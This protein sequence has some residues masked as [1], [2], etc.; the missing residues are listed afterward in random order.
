MLG[1]YITDRDNKS[2]FFRVEKSQ[3]ILY[4]ICVEQ[5]GYCDHK[6]CNL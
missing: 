4:I 5:D 3:E 6:L 1:E 2:E